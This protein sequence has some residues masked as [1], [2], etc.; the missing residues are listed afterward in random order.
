MTGWFERQLGSEVI[1]QDPYFQPEDPEWIQRIR[2][3][4]RDCAITVVTARANQPTPA[5]GEELEDLYSEAWQRKYDQA[6][7]KTEIAVIGGEKTKKSPLHDRWILT[8]GSG[9]R[10]GT[11]LNSL[12]VTKDSEISEMSP[13]QTDQKKREINAYLT[14]ERADYN[15]EKLRLV[16]FWL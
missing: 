4:K 13:E 9:L 14:R 11:S 7:P 3:A 6:P 16:R 2:T 15:G 10:L 5:P 8:D 1:I 12:G